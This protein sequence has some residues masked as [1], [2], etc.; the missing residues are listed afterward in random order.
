[1]TSGI[2]LNL[3]GKRF[4]RLVA[5]HSTDKRKDN[6]IIWECKCD[7]GNLH[8]TLGRYLSDGDT[9]SCG[10]LNKEKLQAGT[11]KLKKGEAALNQLYGNY[12]RQ[13]EI[14]GYFFNLNRE[15]FKKLT[16]QNCFYCGII[17]AQKQTGKYLNGSYTYNGI[18][19]VDNKNGYSVEN[20]V[21][22]CKNCN[23]AKDI[24]LQDEFKLWIENIYKNFI[25]K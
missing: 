19:R 7:C 24:M 25:Q 6:K 1:M 11:T 4:G 3:T 23:R 8:H 17:P 2:P 22:C 5:L 18:D 13:A 14:R 10:C 16:K 20:C 15:Q 12:K 21:P 9:K